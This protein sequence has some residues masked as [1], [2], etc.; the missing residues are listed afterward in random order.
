MNRQVIR[1]GSRRTLSRLALQYVVD[2]YS[3]KSLAHRARARRWDLLSATFPN[4]AEMR[5]LDLGGR[6]TVWATAPV[7]P[8]QVV[9]VNY[10]AHESPEA[11]ITAIEGDACDLPRTIREDHFDLVY[12]NSVIEHVGGHERCLK[13]SESVHSLADSHWVQTP[14]RYFPIEPH[15]ICPG[16]QFLPVPLRASVARVYERVAGYLKSIVA[17]RD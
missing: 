8:K 15:W 11:W 16:L 17:V 10:E 4:L 6:P 13:F 5:V 1:G 12:S 2:P 9:T 14:W 3:P 7:K